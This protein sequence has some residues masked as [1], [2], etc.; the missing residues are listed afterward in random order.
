MSINTRA[1]RVEAP[2]VLTGEQYLE[3]LRE[4]LRL[5]G[6]TDRQARGVTTWLRDKA[7]GRDNYAASTRSR[8]RDWIEEVHDVYGYPWGDDDPPIILDPSVMSSAPEDAWVARLRGAS[9]A[10]RRGARGRLRRVR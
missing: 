3:W 5:L 1:L 8:Y 10:S 4:C 6:R 2:Y 7:N 9:A